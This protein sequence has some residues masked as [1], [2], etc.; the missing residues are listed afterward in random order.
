MTVDTSTDPVYPDWSFGDRIRKARIITGLTQGEF[1]DEIGVKE[2]SLAA[3]ETDRALPRDIVA[4]AKRVE[5]I[6]RIPAGWVL[7]IEV[8]GPPDSPHDKPLSS[9]GL[10]KRRHRTTKPVGGWFTPD[11]LRETG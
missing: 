2:G 4:I 6:T 1:A 9:Q 7:G 11:L 10:S 3:W 8:A 5:M